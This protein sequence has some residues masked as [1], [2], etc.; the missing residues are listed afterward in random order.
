MKAWRYVQ[1]SFM[2]ICIILVAIC[3]NAWAD[4][5]LPDGF[6]ILREKMERQE[7]PE[8]DLSKFKLEFPDP[9][10]D[11]I[12][13]L[14]GYLWSGQYVHPGRRG[15][16]GGS[17]AYLF[18]A[19][20]D[21]ETGEMTFSLAWD[22]GKQTKPGSK[23]LKGKMNPEKQGKTILE[24]KDDSVFTLVVNDK[25]RLTLST[26]AGGDAQMKKIGAITLPK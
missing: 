1:F 4:Q 3:S 12:A 26:P 18:L 5:G 13:T 22:K 10:P 14:K 7:I 9:I 6:A 25:D 19:R 24:G 11:E 8:V 20:V 23:I 15:G 2:I 16:H 17:V 21:K